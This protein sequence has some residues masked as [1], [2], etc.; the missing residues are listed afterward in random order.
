M[1]LKLCIFTVFVLI[2]RSLFE[3]FYIKFNYLCLWELYLS[4]LC[5]MILYN[6]SKTSFMSVLVYYESSFDGHRTS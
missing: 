3:V 2:L 6:N 1:E 5:L 4:Q